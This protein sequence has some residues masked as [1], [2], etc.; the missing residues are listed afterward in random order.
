MQLRKFCIVGRARS[1]T[2]NLA[3]ALNEAYD[4]SRGTNEYRII[5]E[6][7]TKQSGDQDQLIEMFTEPIHETR[8][9]NKVMAQ[10]DTIYGERNCVGTKH[11]FDSLSQVQL[12]AIM[13]YCNYNDIVLLHI[14]RRNKPRCVLSTYLAQQH[15]IWQLRQASDEIKTKEAESYPEFSLEK[16]RNRSFVADGYDKHIELLAEKRDVTYYSISFENL[17]D[18]TLDDQRKEMDCVMIPLNFSYTQVGEIVES[19]KY[20]SVGAKQHD[21]SDFEKIEN[22]EELKPFVMTYE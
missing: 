22:W 16:L 4:T 2:T 9:Y 3:E 11:T 17:F 7:Y 21:W 15:G 18:R 8:S 10:L 20:L 6:P 5:Q 13:D 1:G 12:S 19:S 14:I